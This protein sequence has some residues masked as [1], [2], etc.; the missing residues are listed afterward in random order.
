MTRRSTRRRLFLA[1]TLIICLSTPVWA[2][3]QP[4]PTSPNTGAFS[5]TFN[6]NFPTAYYFRGIAQSNAGFQFEPYAELKATLYS[7][8]EKDLLN[9]AYVKVAGFS[10]IQSTAAPITKN[11][12]E[13]DL[14][15]TGGLVLFKRVTLEGG[16]NLYAY[17]SGLASQVQEVFGKVG[18]DDS[19]LWPFRLPGG[20]DF[21]LSPYVLIAKETSG[22]TDGARP[23]GGHLGTYMELGADPGY[24]VSFSQ[25]WSARFHLPFTLGLS[26]ENYYE[27]ATVTG[28]H[29]KTF[30][31]ADLGLAADVPLG[32]VPARFGKWTFTSG[33]HMLWLGHNAKLL[34]G[35]PGPNALNALNVTGGKGMEV[36]GLTGIKIEY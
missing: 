21:S 36:Y 28:V 11:Y 7:G 3:D 9:S 26:V 15:L 32:F 16:W 24:T 17:P 4:A 14:N 8:E 27:V 22:D 1:A 13:Q 20:Q 33:V 6:L 34:S 30:G 19:G 35:P 2:E 25:D 18:V 10:H 5:F 23:F 12:Y 29:D 31:F